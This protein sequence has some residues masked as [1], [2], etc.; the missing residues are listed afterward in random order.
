MLHVLL[1]Y[2]DPKV[3]HMICGNTGVWA[4]NNQKSEMF[5]DSM[6]SISNINKCLIFK[7]IFSLFSRVYIFCFTCFQWQI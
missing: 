4:V 3:F 7:E 6:I 2:F 1:S 5:L